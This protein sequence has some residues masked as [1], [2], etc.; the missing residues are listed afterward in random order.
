MNVVDLQ[1]KNYILE[2]IINMSE[3][4]SVIELEYHN[5]A[6]G[7]GL[8]SNE[9]VMIIEQFIRMGL[10]EKKGGVLEGVI[11]SVTPYTYR[12][13]KDGGYLKNS[14]SNK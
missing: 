4:S 1:I 6:I 2:D 5:D 13:L 14:D 9:F 7:Y 12:F 8:L 10:L 3:F 11:V